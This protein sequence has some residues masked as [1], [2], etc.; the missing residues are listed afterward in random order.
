MIREHNEQEKEDQQYYQYLIKSDK[1]LFIFLTIFAVFGF[2][3]L[4]MCCPTSNSNYYVNKQ[5][6]NG[7]HY[8][9]EDQLG[10]Q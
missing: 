9:S 8:V 10:Q 3:F 5:H 7:T 6:P 4:I 1:Y 2:I